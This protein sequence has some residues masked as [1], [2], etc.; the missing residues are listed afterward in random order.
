MTQGFDE[1]W[2]AYWRKVGKVDARKTYARKVKCAETHRLVMAAIVSQTPMMLS[3]NPEFRPYASS[4]LNGEHWEDEIEQAPP[5]GRTA[6]VMAQRVS[7]CRECGD[8]GLKYPQ[9]FKSIFDSEAYLDLTDDEAAA[10]LAEEK[11]QMIPC[12]CGAAAR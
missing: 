4:W 6:L 3:R 8:G 5:K 9:G 12:E 1:L 10:L 2:A 11:R 7:K